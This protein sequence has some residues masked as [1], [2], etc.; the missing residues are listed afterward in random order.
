MY[1]GKEIPANAEIKIY[2]GREIYLVGIELNQAIIKFLDT[3]EIK[4]V[5]LNT[6]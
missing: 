3:G 4:R 2:Q 5:T 6:K 1:N